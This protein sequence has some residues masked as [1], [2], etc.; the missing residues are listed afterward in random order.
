[1]AFNPFRLACTGIGRTGSVSKI[2]L[3]ESS[4]SVNLRFPGLW[5]DWKGALFLL[6]GH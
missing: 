1:M 4:F 5:P 6:Y 2:H 3:S